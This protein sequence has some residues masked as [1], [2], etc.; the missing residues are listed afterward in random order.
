M[1]LCR[2][3]IA[4][5]FSWSR[6]IMIKDLKV[7]RHASREMP[8][9]CQSSLVREMRVCAFP[10]RPRQSTI[11]PTLLPHFTSGTTERHLV[12]TTLRTTRIPTL[13]SQGRKKTTLLSPSSQKTRLGSNSPQSHSHRRWHITSTPPPPPYQRYPLHIRLPP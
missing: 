7:S 6:T 2:N 9:E 10:I 1:L 12:G 8:C 5:K 3:E 4:C 13:S 11:R